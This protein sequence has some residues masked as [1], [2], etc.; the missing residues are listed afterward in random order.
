[1]F[2]EIPECPA[3]SPV[4]S[5]A[6][7]ACPCPRC[8][9]AAPPPLTDRATPLLARSPAHRFAR[10]RVPLPVACTAARPQPP[11]ALSP[12]VTGRPLL[13]PSPCHALAARSV[14]GHPSLP[15]SPCHTLAARSVAG[16]RR[17][18]AITTRP[19]SH[20]IA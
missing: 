17:A 9:L 6:P 18:L 14:A 15:P 12:I 10:P 2:D 16:R 5:H 4:A 11:C 8:M 20:A 3:R 1:M 19:M 7:A 13:P